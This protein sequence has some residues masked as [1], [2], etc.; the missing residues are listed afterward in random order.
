M[1]RNPNDKY[2][3]I[4]DT[5]DWIEDETTKE[6]LLFIIDEENRIVFRSLLEE[7]IKPFIQLYDAS[8][9]EKR[10]MMR[11]LYKELPKEGSQKYYFAI[12]KIVGEQHNETWDEIY[13]LPRIPIGL[14]VRTTFQT[15][16]KERNGKPSVEAYVFTQHVNM[17]IHVSNMISKVADIFE[18]PKY[19]LPKIIPC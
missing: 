7:D 13:G 18:I 1:K 19:G 9:S 10:K 12:E 15:A 14:G 5:V 3:I 2:C 11:G 6:R 8:S 16:L 17:T 4:P